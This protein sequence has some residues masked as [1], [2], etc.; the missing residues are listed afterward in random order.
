MN[1]ETGGGILALLFSV[2][3]V[4]A[5]IYAIPDEHDTVRTVLLIVFSILVGASLLNLLRPIVNW[6]SAWSILRTCRRLGIR[7]IHIGLSTK[8][9]VTQLADASKVRIL[10]VSAA[11]LISKRKNEIVNALRKQHAH[12]RILLAQPDSEFVRDIEES[13]SE[14]HRSGDITREIGVVVDHLHRYVD[15]AISDRRI[16]EIGTVEIGFYSTHMRSDLILCDE[17]WG[18]LTIILPP[19]RAQD[20]PC[21]SL[22]LVG[23]RD[24]RSHTETDALPGLLGQCIVHFDRC[25]EIVEQRGDVRQIT[26]TVH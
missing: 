25:W 7:R 10:C 21:V 26:P 17:T 3:A 14:Q 24:D 22:E 1:K 18:W 23:V 19:L 15:D 12:I 20:F 2:I 13:E 8:D 11:A 9:T 4:L 16:G 5:T 6:S